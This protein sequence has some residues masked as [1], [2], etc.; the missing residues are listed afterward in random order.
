[1]SVSSASVAII[2]G[3][4]SGLATAWFLHQ[5]G[6]DV[7]LFESRTEA[8]GSILTSRHDAW[9]VEH[10]PNSTLQ[11]P[12]SPDD[13]LGRL[14]ASLGIEDQLIEAN[15]AAA[16]RFVRRDGV[17]HS[18]PT[19]P[20]AFVKT[21]LFSVG[22]KLRL[23]LEP[24]IGRA[25]EE[26]SIAQF[27][28]RRLGQEFLDYAIEP[29][30]SG[31]YAGDPKTLSVRAA[32]AKIYALEEKYG[33]LIR[34]AIAMGKARKA[35]GMPAGRLVSFKQGM[36]SLPRAI[37]EKLPAGSAHLGAAVTALT[38]Q[39]DGGWSIEWEQQGQAH[40]VTAQQVVLALP[41]P[42][43]AKLVAGFA[44]AATQALEAIPYAP[45]ISLALGFLKSQIDHPMD[46]FGF[47][48][49]RKERI[50]TLGAL[51][52]STLF[53][54]RS[55]ERHALLTCFIGGAMNPGVVDWDDDDVIK[56]VTR[57]LDQCLG[58][59]GDAV[60]GRLTRYQAAIP[61]YTLGHL[62]RIAAVNAALAPFA[63]LYTRAN[64]RD[65]ISVADCVLH[66]EKCAHN[67]LA[68]Q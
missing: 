6:C 50:A 57:D 26:E 5:A 8:G 31:V 32:T 54:E 9:L 34:G 58:V 67:L 47:L 45:I 55:D 33:S 20:P 68:T 11:K 12:D 29:F 19:S 2:G 30:V 16:K 59:R 51:F 65:G 40:Q 4:V 52:N 14:I 42:A 1:M 22:G 18:L 27:V 23:A 41:A 63:G 36:Q 60:F 35:A 39:S 61:Q 38:P 15:A 43:A 7:Q 49:P 21:P 24:L 62:S 13:G 66:A 46:G 17:M 44:P 37:A 28:R 3:G 56:Q 53:P 10:G 64:W 48:L 25:S